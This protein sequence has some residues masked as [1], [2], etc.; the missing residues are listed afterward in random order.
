MAK[1][2]A[3]KK[4]DHFEPRILSEKELQAMWNRWHGVKTRDIKT[5]SR[6][7]KNGDKIILRMP[8]QVAYEMDQGAA[9]WDRDYGYM[10]RPGYKFTEAKSF[11][12]QY[13]RYEYKREEAEKSQMNFAEV[14]EYNI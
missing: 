3:E 13:I 7:D 2:K 11:W 9:G 14:P 6:T 4:V 12:E 8:R 5:E 1:E 10:V